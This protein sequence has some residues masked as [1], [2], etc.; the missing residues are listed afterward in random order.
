[1]LKQNSSSK[2]ASTLR[3]SSRL[4]TSYLVTGLYSNM[5][6]LY[7]ILCWE[8]RKTVSGTEFIFSRI[9]THSIVVLSGTNR[10]STFE[11]YHQYNEPVDFTYAI[12]NEESPE[13]LRQNLILPRW[14]DW[15]FQN[16]FLVGKWAEASFAGRGKATLESLEPSTAC[17]NLLLTEQLG[18]WCWLFIVCV[19]DGVLLTR[20]LY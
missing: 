18:D 14:E 9:S 4:K 12:E 6:L 5:H 13:G 19:K 20:R 16:T 15:L 2:W 3:R 7:Y 10:A 17:C 1:M 8:S 11:L